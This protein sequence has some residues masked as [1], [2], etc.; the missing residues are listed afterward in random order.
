MEM[1]HNLSRPL[2]YILTCKSLC[3]DRA[4]WR[5]NH[6][7]EHEI[8]AMGEGHHYD[9]RMQLTHHPELTYWPR[10]VGEQRSL[11]LTSIS[12]QFRGR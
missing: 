4:G 2:C 10:L 3:I 5:V 7:A 12:G 8:R 9:G 6:D 11:Q 1:S